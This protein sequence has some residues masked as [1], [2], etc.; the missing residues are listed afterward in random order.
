MACRHGPQFAMNSIDLSE[1][2][3]SKAEALVLAMA[4]PGIG[5]GPRTNVNPPPATPAYA[6]IRTWFKP[7]EIHL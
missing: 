4:L 5:Y 1:A 2:G 6:G 7:K 3:C